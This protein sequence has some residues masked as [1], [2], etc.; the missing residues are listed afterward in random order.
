M[1]MTH[2]LYLQSPN[3][4]WAELKDGCHTNSLSENKCCFVLASIGSLVARLLFRYDTDGRTDASSSK[5]A[6]SVSA[7]LDE[8]EMFSFDMMRLRPALL[9]GPL[10]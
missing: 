1:K 2:E 6:L 7:L 5:K 4:K 10:L 3:I 8:V 9:W